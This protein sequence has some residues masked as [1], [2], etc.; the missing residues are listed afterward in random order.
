MTEAQSMEHEEEE[1]R[2]FSCR[3]R[4]AFR[5]EKSLSYWQPASV[6]VNEGEVRSVSQICRQMKRNRCQINVHWRQVVEK[7]AYRGRM[8]K[9]D[10][11]RTISAWDVGILSPRKKQSK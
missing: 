6:V 11:E 7:K 4:L 9:N 1:E 10:G 3:A 5:C 8:W 2:F